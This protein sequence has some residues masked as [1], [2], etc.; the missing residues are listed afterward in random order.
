L[1]LPP[2]HGVITFATGQVIVTVEQTLRIITDVA[3]N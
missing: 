3:S 1:R 2:E